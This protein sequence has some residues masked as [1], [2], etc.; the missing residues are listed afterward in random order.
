MI[1]SEG[2]ATV[3]LFECAAFALALAASNL[4][5][6]AATFHIDTFDAGVLGWAGGFT[7]PDHVTTGGPAGAGDGHLRVNDN[8]HVAVHNISPAWTGDMTALGAT[9]VDVDL[10]SPVS[11]PALEI[12]LVLFATDSVRW[13]SSA[14]YVLPKDG[15]WRRYS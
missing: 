5:A 14:G 4:P 11:S 12:R 9:R 1:Y 10:M 7:P 3:K 2:F 6:P 8:G 15:A 13:A